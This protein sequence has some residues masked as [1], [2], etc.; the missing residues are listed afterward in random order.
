MLE[1]GDN[2]RERQV[3]SEVVS[4]SYTMLH[5]GKEVQ[6]EYLR[7]SL[8]VAVIGVFPSTA[9]GVSP[10]TNSKKVCKLLLFIG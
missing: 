6:T 1:N 5:T 7:P 8:P 10:L 9:G 2:A 3:S 4:P